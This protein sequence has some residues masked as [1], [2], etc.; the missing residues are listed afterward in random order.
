MARRSILLKATILFS[1]AGAAACNDIER[2]RI[3]LEAGYQAHYTECR[4]ELDVL[5]RYWP[6]QNDCDDNG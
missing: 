2:Q 6:S 5:G 4:G 1:L 3:W